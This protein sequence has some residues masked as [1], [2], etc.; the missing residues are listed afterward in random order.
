[1]FIA[2]ATP[3]RAQLRR[4]AMFYSA[5]RPM[6]SGVT[7]HSPLR[8]W[9]LFSSAAIHIPPRWGGRSYLP[10]LA[11]NIAP[12]TG[13]GRLLAGGRVADVRRPNPKGRHANSSHRPKTRP[14]P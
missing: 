13:L 12:L 3:N 7:F 4:S 1:M 11:I 9:V 6:G 5:K 2:P 14:P 10:P 8:G